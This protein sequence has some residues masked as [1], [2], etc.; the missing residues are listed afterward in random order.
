MNFDTIIKGG[1]VVT[2]SDTFQADIGILGETIACIGINLK[3]D[4]PCQEIDASGKI[5]IPGG[6]DV[7]V[8]LQ[9]PFCGT[10]SSDDFLTGTKAAARGGVTTVIDF[11]IQDAEKGLMAGIEARM[12]EADPKVCVDYALHSIIT[13]WNEAIK[14]E[15]TEVI[16]FGIPT[17]KMFMI[18]EKEGWQSDD[19]A[20]FSALEATAK[21]G[22]RICV[23]AESEKVMSHLIAKYLPEKEKHGAY[24]HV[25]SRPNY[26]EAEAVQRVIKWAEVT[27]GRLYIVHLST[28]EAAHLVWEAQQM[29]IDVQAETCPQYLLLDDEVF[30]DPDRGHLFATCP[31]IKKQEDSE[32]LWEAL[33]AGELTIVAT[34][35]CT[36]DTKQKAMWDGDFTKIPFGMPGVET[37]LP[38][39]YTAGVLEERFSLNHFVSLISANPAK[40]M[41]LYPQKGALA[42]GSDA[43]VVIIDPQK[44][45]EVDWQEL[46]TNCDWSPFQGMELA[47]FAET[48]LSRGK[49]VVKDG[50]F[51]GNQ[52]HGKFV[53]RQA[54]G[55]V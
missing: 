39:V 30:K 4:A 14:R 17:F 2:A 35:T 40:L 50:A 41:G 47:G 20:L 32:R 55:E 12:Q 38:S 26:I 36:F 18:Y 25:L 51:V 16:K 6:I 54:W 19:A 9:L 11:A 27:G 22:A 7:H 46:A 1:T 53:K 52:G 15:M 10:V 28:G 34:D 44:K 48:T 31:Q 29:G 3:S 24:A 43:D 5:V 45:K 23:H 8:H 49:V 37:L 33:T 21:N 42:V 13:N